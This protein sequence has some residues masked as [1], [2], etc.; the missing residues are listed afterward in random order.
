[1]PIE[2][3]T[4]SVKKQAGP[5]RVREFLAPKDSERRAAKGTGPRWPLLEV[6]PKQGGQET[7]V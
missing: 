3:K 2:P 6:T 1:M 7:T 4:W 5:L